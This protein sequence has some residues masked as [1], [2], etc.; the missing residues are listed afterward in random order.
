MFWSLPWLTAAAVTMTTAGLAPPY[1]PPRLVEV[2]TVGAYS[3]L[4]FNAFMFGTL[5]SIDSQ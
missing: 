5:S 2:R 4:E 3:G 1:Q